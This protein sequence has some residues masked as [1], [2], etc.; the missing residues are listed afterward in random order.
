M[1][2]DGIRSN[3]EN[4]WQLPTI[5]NLK[6]A[7][8]R[9]KNVERCETWHAQ[10]EEWL[11]DDWCNAM[12]GEAGESQNIIKKIRRIESGT[13]GNSEGVTMESL[14]AALGEELADIVTY[15]DLV[16]HYHCERQF[17]D[18]AY[19]SFRPLLDAANRNH[20]NLI[21]ALYA[22]TNRSVDE[23]TFAD[24]N[25]MLDVSKIPTHELFGDKGPAG[26]GCY[27]SAMVGKVCAMAFEGSDSLPINYV[28]FPELTMEVFIACELIAR[29]FNINL[30]EEV[31]TKFNNVSEK[32]HIDIWL[33]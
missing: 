11:I 8:L 13:G 29:K 26:L 2:I 15:A 5:Q 16:M 7:K 25:L 24:F 4:R 17:F 32:Q 12:S 14:V 27:L 19:D 1:I 9:E 31:I 28:A 33:K 6:F 20:I 22:G 18:V 3:I 10:G 21:D 30:S 23:M